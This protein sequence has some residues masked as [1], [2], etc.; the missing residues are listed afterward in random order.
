LQVD[1]I[2]Q[3]LNYA[4]VTVLI[5]ISLSK[6]IGSENLQT[7]SYAEFRDEGL[8]QVQSCLE[9]L[10]QVANIYAVIEIIYLSCPNRFFTE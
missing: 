2:L 10:Q 4:R 6:Q 3:G 8:P 9:Y 7:V 5:S 1:V